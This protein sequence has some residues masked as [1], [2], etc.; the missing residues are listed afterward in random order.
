MAEL[1][2]GVGKQMV[3]EKVRGRRNTRA[4]E[5]DLQLPHSP[6]S[7]PTFIA[8][9]QED[10]CSCCGDTGRAAESGWSRDRTCPVD[11]KYLLKCQ[12]WCVPRPEQDWVLWP[13]HPIC[14]FKRSPLTG[15]AKGGCCGC[16]SFRRMKNETS[17][18]LFTAQISSCFVVSSCLFSIY[19]LES[20]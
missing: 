8:F 20:E 18:V 4:G 15:E 13:P 9:S 12:Y 6:A 14:T 2:H 5:P 11:T 3:A 19:F 1:P 10:K 16:F 7:P 17:P